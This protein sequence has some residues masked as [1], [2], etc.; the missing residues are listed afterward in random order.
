MKILGLL[1][2]TNA[3][4]KS[5]SW[6]ILFYNVIA[7]FSEIRMHLAGSAIPVKWK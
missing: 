1:S 2:I 5:S 3:S 6:L 7:M 4:I